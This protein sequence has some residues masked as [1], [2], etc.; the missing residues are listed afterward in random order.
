METVRHEHR[1]K[2]PQDCVRRT[3]GRVLDGLYPT[4]GREKFRTRLERRLRLDGRGGYFYE[5]THVDQ[6]HPS[7]Q[8]FDVRLRASGILGP[9]AFFFLGA[10]TD[11]RYALSP[12]PAGRVPSDKGYRY[13]VEALME[14]RDL[15]REVKQPIRHQFHQAGRDQDEWIQLAASVLARAVVA[16]LAPGRDHAEQHAR[17]PTATRAASEDI[18]DRLSA[19]AV[20]VLVGSG[21]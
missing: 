17:K 8:G 12:L 5:Q 4:R 20:A 11:D 16:D 14:E 9:V 1:S 6:A 15:P 7:H 10:V 2:T 18:I 3:S 13:Y 21:D 19:G